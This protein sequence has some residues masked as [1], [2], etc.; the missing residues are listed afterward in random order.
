MLKVAGVKVYPRQTRNLR[1]HAVS[2]CSNHVTSR[3]E[4]NQNKQNQQ[5]GLTVI[6]LNFKIKITKTI[7]LER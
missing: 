4:K 5:P 2:A 3:D 6:A 7:H 1:T